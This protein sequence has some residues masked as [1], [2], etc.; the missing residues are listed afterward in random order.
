MQFSF[1]KSKVLGITVITPF[2][3]KDERGFLL[4]S[5]EKDVFAAAGI[6]YDIQEDFES[7]SVQGVIRGLHFQKGQAQDKLVRAIRGSIFDVAV[8]LRPDSDTFGK[9]EGTYISDQNNLS[10]LIPK[11]FAHGF[12][13]LSESALVS[14][15]CAGRYLKEYDSGIVWNDKTIGVEW[16]LE[17]GQLPIVSERDQ[18]LQTFEEY[19]K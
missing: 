6:S 5:F 14:Y 9:W 12:M 3:V 10:T 2:L 17:K 4:K 13:V 16:P 8:D 19:I 1:E 7:F 15:K 18:R 11:G